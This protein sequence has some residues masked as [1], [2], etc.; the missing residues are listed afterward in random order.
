MIRWQINRGRRN[1]KEHTDFTGPHFVECYVVWNKVCIARAYIDV[2][3]DVGNGT[4]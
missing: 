1:I 3:I 2:P 4:V